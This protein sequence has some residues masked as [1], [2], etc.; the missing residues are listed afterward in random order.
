[1]NKIDKFAES[2]SSTFN[3]HSQKV[4]KRSYKDG[5][6]EGYK[7]SNKNIMDDWQLKLSNDY[8][9]LKEKYMNL[10]CKYEFFLN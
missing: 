1:M 3:V 4:S 8:S 9:D 10:K 7:D 5:Y 6:I 2:Y